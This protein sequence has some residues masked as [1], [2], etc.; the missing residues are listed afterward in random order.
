MSVVVEYL[1]LACALLFRHAPFAVV[2]QTSEI[3]TPLF[4]TF[5]KAFISDSMDFLSATLQSDGA[6]I[7]TPCSVLMSGM[8]KMVSR[9]I[10]AAVILR[11]M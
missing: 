10:S 11:F 9:R 2:E 5:G 3:E 7:S 6:T 4:G 1:F 8:R